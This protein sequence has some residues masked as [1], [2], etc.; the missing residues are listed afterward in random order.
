MLLFLARVYKMNLICFHQY[1]AHE[2]SKL[3]QHF[4]LALL[5]K[6]LKN[7]FQFQMFPLGN[8]L[9][10][11]CGLSGPAVVVYSEIKILENNF[12]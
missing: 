10:A 3:L 1:T 5:G 12:V 8:M 4:F 7:I 6:G 9:P 11:P 2:F